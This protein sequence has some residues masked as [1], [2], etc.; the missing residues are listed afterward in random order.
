MSI[1]LLEQVVAGQAPSVLPLTVAYDRTTKQRLYAAASISPYWI[2]NLV[3]HQIE[4]YEQPL[5]SE[6]RY[7]ARTDYRPG[8]TIDLILSPKQT[9]QVRVSDILPTEPTV[10]N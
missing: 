3:D 6:A 5:P 9:I 4:I 10:Q 1:S 8:Q 2:V 7:A